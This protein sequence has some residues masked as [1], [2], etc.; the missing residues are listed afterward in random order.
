MTNRENFSYSSLV[1]FPLGGEM[2]YFFGAFFKRFILPIDFVEK[3]R[4]YD[5][6]M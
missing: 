4:Q 5:K 3:F 1:M 6:I 2:Q